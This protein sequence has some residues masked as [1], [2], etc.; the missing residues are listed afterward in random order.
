MK[1]F[2]KKVIIY[3]VPVFLIYLFPLVLYVV[4][5]EYFSLERV[6]ELQHKIPGTIYG[7]SYYGEPHVPYKMLLIKDKIPDVFVL[8]TSRSFQIRKEFFVQ[9][10]NYVN[11]AVPRPFSDLSTLSRFTEVLPQDG[12][13]RT[14]FLLL[15]KRYFT[16]EYE[17]K[18]STKEDTFVAQFKKLVGK[19][20]RLVYLDYFSR[21]Y[22]LHDLV[23]ASL[24]TDDRIGLWALIAN[25][26]YRIDGTHQEEYATQRSDRKKLLYGEIESRLYQIAHYDPVLLQKE[27][28]LI[29]KNIKALDDFLLL[30]KERNITV[31]GFIPPDPIEVSSVI[32]KGDTL[33]SQSQI[34]LTST[35]ASV[36]LSNRQ[37]FFNL[38]S[39]QDFG[40]SDDEFI[41]LIHG[42][43]L[44][45]ARAFLFMALQDPSLKQFV[46][47]KVLQGMIK[48]THDD[49]L[50]IPY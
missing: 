18:F 40:G 48:N 4:S 41:D 38:S 49:F 32:N 43:D 26:G 30:C 39:I 37:R 22:T 50:T 1:I 31:V 42:G 21:R 24:H 45:Y 36:F 2:I 14:L 5:K 17:E 35:I 46:N 34:K 3:I 44:L 7:F 29:L 8:G 19:P 23:D 33:Y 13:Q 20:L 25:T 6:V 11:A 28:S 27:E 47:A 15:D 16:E 9:P 12:K 10:E